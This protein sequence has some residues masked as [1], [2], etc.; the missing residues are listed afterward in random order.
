MHCRFL[1]GSDSAT[2]SPSN[3]T[4]ISRRVKSKERAGRARKEIK[5]RVRMSSEGE[6]VSPSAAV[7]QRKQKKSSNETT[8]TFLKK[9]GLENYY[10]LFAEQE[11]DRSA[12]KEL[13][14]EDLE[15]IGVTS[16]THRSAII[17]SINE[18]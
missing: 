3:S 18:K 9:L 8:H 15:E 2:N 12:L 5:Y 13:T 7:K 17:Q 4:G 11:I 14:D 1:A 6:E 16:A 10:K